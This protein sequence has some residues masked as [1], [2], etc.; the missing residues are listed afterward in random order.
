VRNKMP[1]WTLTAMTVAGILSLICQSAIADMNG[2]E[3]ALAFMRQGA[4]RMIEG[5]KM[6]QDKKDSGSG[7]KAIKDGHRMMMQAEKTVAQIQK[8]SLKQGAKLMIDGLQVLRTRNDQGEAEKLMAQGQK[9][10]LEGE[11]IMADTRSEKLMEGSRTMMRG[12]RMMQEKDL[13][14]ADR[15]MKDGQTRML[16]AEKK[17]K[18]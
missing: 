2:W 16:G 11:K 14:T 8:D 18:D 17:M 4:D 3:S 12:L 7:E 10:I 15:L 6:L 1:K 5:R 13:K 9:M